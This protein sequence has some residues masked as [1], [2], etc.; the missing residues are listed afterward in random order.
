MKRTLLSVKSPMEQIFAQGGQS[1]ARDGVNVK[2]L[3]DI[4][5]STKDKVIRWHLRGDTECD[6]VFVNGDLILDCDLKFGSTF[7][8]D[9]RRIINLVITGNLTVHGTLMQPENEEMPS[10]VYVGGTLRAQNV[11]TGGT[12]WVNGDLHVDAALIGDGND[13]SAHIGGHAYAQ[14]F[15]P[16]YH[17]FDAGTATFDVALGRDAKYRIKTKGEQ[18]IRYLNDSEAAFYLHKPATISARGLLSYTS[19]G[20]SIFQRPLSTPMPILAGPA[21]IIEAAA[22]NNIEAVRRF[23]QDGADVNQ[24]TGSKITALHRAAQHNNPVLIQLLLDA[25][26]NINARTSEGITPLVQSYVYNGYIEIKQILINAGANPNIA[27]KY[28]SPL[29]QALRRDELVKQLLDAGADPCLK[30]KQGQTAFDTVVE[31]KRNSE[32]SEKMIQLL[33]RYKN[34]G[35]LK[36]SPS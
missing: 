15:F 23:L 7:V 18:H 27:S 19:N 33:N 28:G 21:N 13:Y 8:L 11:H 14:I 22:A 12:L 6:T 4:A 35:T 20:K 25:G 9:K 29:D 3:H 17:F 24:K 31:L 1:L 36:A 10:L 5:A 26:A 30:N 34:N 16:K 2:Q 32:W